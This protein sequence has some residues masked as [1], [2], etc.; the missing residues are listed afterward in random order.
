MGVKKVMKIILFAILAVILVVL[1]FFMAISTG[2]V[3]PYRD[4][5]GN[6]L[7]NSLSEKSFVD[8]NG[9]KNGMFINSKNINNPVLLLISSGPGTD[10][11]FFNE[12]YKDMHLE[13]EF[14]V[15]YWNYRGMGICYDSKLDPNTITMDAIVEDCATMTDYLRNRFNQDK[16]YLL[17]FSGGS[18]IGIRAAKKYPEK[19]K[20]YIGM[21]QVIS[22]G[23][24]NDTYIYNFMKDVFTKRGDN[25]RLAKLE[26]LVDHLENDEVKCNN[27]FSFIYLLHEAGG[28]TT[29]NETEFWGIDVPIIMSSC[30]TLKEK[31][32]YIAGM[33]MYRKTPLFQESESADYMKE[34]PS[35]EIPVYFLSGEYDYNC[36]WPMV[37]KY[38]NFLQAPDKKFFKISNAAHSPL[39]ENVPESHKALCEIKRA[40]ED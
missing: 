1:I 15:V 35:L 12:K 16:I 13:D 22:K 17:G 27:W 24:E 26:S 10:D 4:E 6:I 39:W 25:G 31:F 8:I 36:P 9:Y 30:Y 11:Y 5:N 18:H 38:C 3:K 14:T 33:K 37:E 28:G 32:D 21:A 34:I 20:A 2:K 29:L 19:Y 23:A 40:L 7:E